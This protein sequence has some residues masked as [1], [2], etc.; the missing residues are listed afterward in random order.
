MHTSIAP[1][2]STLYFFI[3]QPNQHRYTANTPTQP[4]P[5]HTHHACTTN[6]PT[7]PTLLHTQPS[8]TTNTPTQ[9]TPLH[10]QPSRTTN[11]PAPPASTHDSGPSR[12][13][14]G[15]AAASGVRPPHATSRWQSPA[16]TPTP[17]TA[18]SMPASLSSRHTALASDA[19]AYVCPSR[20][21]THVRPLTSSH[22][23]R[24]HTRRLSPT[25]CRTT[26]LLE[27]VLP[28]HAAEQAPGIEVADRHAASETVQEPGT[29][30]VCRHS[31]SVCLAVRRH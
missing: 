31:H 7:Q 23:E 2:Q 18:L 11:V 25:P 5:L 8:R 13:L 9:P 10:S 29:P 27:T 19:R 12:V 20:V 24:L 28:S 14:S 17:A 16:A 22:D 30:A 21:A 3:F 15:G 26:G 6:T 1:A 4:T